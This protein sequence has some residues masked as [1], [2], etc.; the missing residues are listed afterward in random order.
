LAATAT[1]LDIWLM[2]R[3]VNYVRVGYSSVSYTMFGLCRD[4]RG[5][6]VEELVAILRKKLDE[7]DVTFEGYKARRR[8]GLDALGLNQFT[9]RYI[10]HLLARITSFVEVGSGRTE[11]FDKLVDRSV[12]NPFDVEHIWA[13]NYS[14]VSDQFESE[15]DFDDWRNNAASLLLLPADVN[16]SL[17]DKSYVNKIPHYAKQNLWAASLNQSVYQHQPK[18]EQFRDAHSLTFG[19]LSKFGKDEQRKRRKLLADLTGIIW[20]PNRLDEVMPMSDINVI[21]TYHG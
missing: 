21:K 1:Y 9:R 4:I 7:D 10:S 14:A 15:Q 6:S 2:R 13:D 19:H 5:K 3:V 16:R 18:F 17:Q 8:G 20:S 12:K 11:S